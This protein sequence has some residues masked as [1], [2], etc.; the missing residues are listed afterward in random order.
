MKPSLARSIGATAL[1]DMGYEGLTEGA[2]EAIS[3]TAENFIANRPNVFQSK[4]WD[5][6]IEST[7]KGGVAGGGF[8][9]VGGVAERSR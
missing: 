9:A 7:V 5:R 3:I 2:Q 6:I 1:K 4:D 8:G